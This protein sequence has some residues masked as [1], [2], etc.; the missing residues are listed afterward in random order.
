M[1]S[2][3]N[4]LVRT[5]KDARWQLKAECLGGLE[6]DDHLELGRLLNWKIGRLGTP[7]NL[8]DVVSCVP[9]H[10]NKICPIGSLNCLPRSV[11][12]LP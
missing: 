6:V 8:V 11:V 9:K 12:L 4:Q 10:I 7:E 5:G 2:P 3:F 1:A